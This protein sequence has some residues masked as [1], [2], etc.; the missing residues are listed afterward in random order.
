MYGLIWYIAS[1]TILVHLWTM[2]DSH[3]IQFK[4]NLPVSLKSRLQLLAIENNRSLTGEIIARLEET[5][6][7]SDDIGSDFSV[8]SLE[9]Y[10]SDRVRNH[11]VIEDISRAIFDLQ[12]AIRG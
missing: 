11:E 12:K 7:M 10:V 5:I 4:L 3:S 2:T 6:L 1:R 9:T 8:E